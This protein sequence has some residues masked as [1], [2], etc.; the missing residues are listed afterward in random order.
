M[1]CSFVYSHERRTETSTGPGTLL[2]FEG[3]AKARVPVHHDLPTVL[4]VR[5]V[6]I[7]H[8]QGPNS[9]GINSSAVLISEVVGSAPLSDVLI[10]RSTAP[11][12]Y[13]GAHPRRRTRKNSRRDFGLPKRSTSASPK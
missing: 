13:R 1:P 8:R 9:D 12:G 10:I 2:Q 4:A 7:L 11:R 3:Q 5:G 6:A